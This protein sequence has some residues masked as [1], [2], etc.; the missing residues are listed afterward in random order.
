MPIQPI[1]YCSNCFAP[2]P[3]KQ[4]SQGEIIV[5]KMRID[6]EKAK[7]KPKNERTLDDKISIIT[8]GINKITT[9][10]IIFLT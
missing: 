2:S 4:P 10:I 3:R 1:N 6:A 9:N 8:N 5:E 7:A